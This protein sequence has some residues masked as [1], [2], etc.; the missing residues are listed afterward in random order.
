MHGS[1]HR[2]L[3]AFEASDLGPMRPAPRHLPERVGRFSII[4]ELGRGGLGVVYLAEDPHLKRR[5]AL[6]LPRENEDTQ[7]LG[8]KDTQLF[9]S[10]GSTKTLNSS[11]FDE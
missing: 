2:E 1:D 10:R 4:G 6:K 8:N 9:A 5:V 7:L 11:P 3:S